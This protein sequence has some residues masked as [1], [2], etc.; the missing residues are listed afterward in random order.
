MDP[1]TTALLGLVLGILLGMAAGIVIGRT[2]S[3]PALPAKREPVEPRRFE[4]IDRHAP[5]G[6]VAA[7]K[8]SGYETAR[9]LKSRK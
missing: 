1:L 4:P 3:T 5:N 7:Q 8:R 2:D 6:Q 9:E